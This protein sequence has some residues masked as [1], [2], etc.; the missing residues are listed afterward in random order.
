MKEKKSKQRIVKSRNT[1]KNRNKHQNVKLNKKRKFTK[2]QVNYKFH[3]GA[4]TL[5]LATATTA[6]VA[7]APSTST[8]TNNNTVPNLD[9]S[10]MAAIDQELGITPGATPAGDVGAS[11]LGEGAAEP[12]LGAGEGEEPMPSLTVPGAGEGAELGAGEGE[13]PTPSLTVPGAGEGEEGAPGAP[14]AGAD[15]GAAEPLPEDEL[16][17]LLDEQLSPEEQEDLIGSNIETP[18]NEI[19][20]PD[21]SY[22][23][24]LPIERQIEISNEE[25][26]YIPGI[27]VISTL[28]FILETLGLTPE[29]KEKKEEDKSVRNITGENVNTDFDK[30]IVDLGY[31]NKKDKHKRLQ[32]EAV[33][34]NTSTLNNIIREGK[35]FGNDDE[36]HINDLLEMVRMLY[37][38]KYSD[39]QWVRAASLAE[40]IY[41]YYGSSMTREQFFDSN[42]VLSYNKL[43]NIEEYWKTD[44]IFMTKDQKARFMEALIFYGGNDTTEPLNIT[45]TNEPEFV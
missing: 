42:K 39:E 19:P 45:A 33:L 29:E 10:E 6:T 17:K 20:E 26:Y 31:R 18:A 23:N 14:G 32:P 13:E 38:Y 25:G 11:E 12:G 7:G 28:N 37:K 44:F 27:D 43:K 2:S 36:L 24:S 35:K 40:T 9:E 21:I 1:R 15:A 8:S 30:V 34:T 4:D 41:Q 22:Y 16:Q 3:G 5:P